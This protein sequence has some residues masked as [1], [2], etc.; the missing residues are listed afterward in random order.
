MNFRRNIESN[1]RFWS[2]NQD[3]TFSALILSTA[4]SA[5][6]SVYKRKH[7]HVS[8]LASTVSIQISFHCYIK[9]LINALSRPQAGG[10]R[11]APGGGVVHQRPGS[12]PHRTGHPLLLPPLLQRLLPED[13]PR[14]FRT[15]AFLLQPLRHVSEELLLPGS[16]AM[17][18]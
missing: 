8:R 18:Y 13:L 7:T 9:H 3:M 15:A 1:V 11:P 5:Y 12:R 17:C 2:Q 10:L 14:G 16:L 4:L 6:D